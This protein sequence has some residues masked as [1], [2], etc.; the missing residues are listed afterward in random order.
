MLEGAVL[1]GMLKANTT[2]NP[3]LH[4]ERSK[5]RRN[6]VLELLQERGHLTRAETD[7][8]RK[9]PC[10]STTPVATHLISTATS[11]I[12][13]SRKRVSFSMRQSG[14]PGSTTTWRKTAYA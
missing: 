10:V 4:P 13:W 8:R 11:T 6:Q 5:G 1:V 7:S 12:K 9:R 2:F 14:A 3:R